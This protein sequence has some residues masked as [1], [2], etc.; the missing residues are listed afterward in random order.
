MRKYFYLFAAV[1]AMSLAGCSG[2]E[3]LESASESKTNVEAKPITFE[4]A[5]VDKSTRATTPSDPSATVKTLGSFYA[6]G[7]QG[8]NLLFNGQEVSSTDNGSTWSYS[9]LKYWVTNANYYFLGLANQGSKATVTPSL[10]DSKAVQLVV[11]GFVDTGTADL[12]ASLQSNVTGAQNN[13]AVAL[14]FQHLLAKVKFTFTNSFKSTD[15]VTLKVKNVKITNCDSTATVTIVGGASAN[16]VTWSSFTAVNSETGGLNFGATDSIAPNSGSDVAQKQ[17]LIIPNKK[18]YTVTFNVD[19]I[20]N[21]TTGAK[22]DKFT[23]VTYSHEITIKDLEFKSGYSYNLTA[24]L[25]KDNVNPDASIAP[26]TFTVSSITDWT[27]A[28]DK[29]FTPSYTRE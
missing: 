5:F 18:D 14:T 12:L 11:A 28:D 3:V 17:L 9:P 29:S 16:T 15:D 26:I 2:D 4:N 22:G 25:D 21:A 1:A 19:V 10:T 13:S 23:T 8:S 7:Y 6:Y 20:A 24:S 27:S